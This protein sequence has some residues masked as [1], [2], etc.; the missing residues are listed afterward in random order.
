MTG[1]PIRAFEIGVP[2][3][4]VSHKVLE[5]PIVWLTMFLQ[6]TGTKDRPI[7]VR[8]TCAGAMERTP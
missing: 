6:T 8:I 7:P 4:D 2:T 5:P 1:D 3:F